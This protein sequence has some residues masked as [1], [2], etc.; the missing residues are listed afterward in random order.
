MTVHGTIGCECFV[1][2]VPELT[3]DWLWVYSMLYYM[4]NFRVSE[5]ISR[6]SMRSSIVNICNICNL[7]M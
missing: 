1:W 3:V 5:K 6:L 7:F 2:G 4:A